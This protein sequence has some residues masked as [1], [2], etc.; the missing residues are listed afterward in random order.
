FG[1]RSTRCAPVCLFV[2]RMHAPGI[3]APL[4]SRTRPAMVPVGAWAWTLPSVINP[5]AKTATIAALRLMM[6]LASCQAAVAGCPPGFK[7]FRCKRETLPGALGAALKCTRAEPR[8]MLLRQADLLPQSLHARIAPKKRHLR[9]TIEELSYS[10]WPQG[11]HT[12]ESFQRAVFVAETGEDQRLLVRILG[13]AG[14]L[15]SL[16]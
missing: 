15:L 12:I 4:G 2:T 7:E 8:S 16:L 5:Q 1:A 6:N 3:A 13:S 10:D 14:H 11:S 9:I